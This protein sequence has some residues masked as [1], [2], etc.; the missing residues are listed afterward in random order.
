MDPK[1]IAPLPGWNKVQEASSLNLEGKKA[2]TPNLALNCTPLSGNTAC[3]DL[4]W[5]K[6]Y[7]TGS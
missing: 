6:Q 4:S 1:L 2:L 3:Q 7:L 5:A